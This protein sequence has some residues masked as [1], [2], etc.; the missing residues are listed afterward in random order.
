MNLHPPE[1]LENWN[2]VQRF[3]SYYRRYK[4]FFLTRGKGRVPVA[5]QL[6]KATYLSLFI[7]HY[8]RKEEVILVPE[9]YD[10]IFVDDPHPKKMLDKAS[11]GTLIIQTSTGKFQLHIP[12][13]KTIP[14]SHRKAYQKAVQRIF[15]SEYVHWNHGR[16]IPGFYNWK[17]D[18]PYLVQVIDFTFSRPF[19]EFWLELE[20]TARTIFETE[21]L[22][23]KL[24]FEELTQKLSELQIQPTTPLKTWNDFYSGDRSQADLRY[25][26]YLLSRGLSIQEVIERLLQESPDILKRKKGHLEDYLTRTLTKAIQKVIENYKPFK[27]R[28]GFYIAV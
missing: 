14:E 2:S 24:N 23:I 28:D 20:N 26:I 3:L 27:K 9:E 10:T 5:S 22:Y 13:I 4:V 15:A 18:P 16:K 25:T 12:I 7:K 8:H 11:K 21:S 19:E 6:D 1:I 17:Y